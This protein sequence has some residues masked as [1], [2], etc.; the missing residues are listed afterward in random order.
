MVC[1]PI[2]PK[3][4]ERRLR[5]DRLLVPPLLRP[6]DPPAL[7][8]LQEAGHNPERARD[9]H[10]AGE[11]RMIKKE[12]FTTWQPQ[13]RKCAHCG[14]MAS[15]YYEYRVSVIPDGELF[16]GGVR[17][18]HDKGIIQICI[19][20]V[21]NWEQDRKHRVYSPKGTQF[22]MEEGM[23]IEGAVDCPKPH[24]MRGLIE[25]KSP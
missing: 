7:P 21:R 2:V 10:E 19:Y 25:E 6:H 12:E 5:N 11:I 23:T 1:G 8:S 13:V 18:E 17:P 3:N 15:L 9:G 14:N 20:C 4:V 22:L 24:K 16:G